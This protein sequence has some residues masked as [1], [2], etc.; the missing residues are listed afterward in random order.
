MQGGIDVVKDT[1]NIIL[2]SFCTMLLGIN[3]VCA[4]ALHMG[5][6]LDEP[7]RDGTREC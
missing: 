6:D 3:N 1:A 4:R 2:T 5:M 7:G